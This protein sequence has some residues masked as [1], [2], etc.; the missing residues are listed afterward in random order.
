MFI[1]SE[2]HQYKI[3]SKMEF[4]IDFE[5]KIY[6]LK[7]VLAK[8]DIESSDT[9]RMDFGCVSN[10]SVKELGGGINQLLYLQI[11]D[12]RDRQ[13]D[14]VNYEVSEFERESVYFFCQD[15]KITRFS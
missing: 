7:L 6:N 9:I 5:A 15:V 13:W 11:K 1:N 14:R 3:I 4:N 2:Y 10:F 8:D 12:I